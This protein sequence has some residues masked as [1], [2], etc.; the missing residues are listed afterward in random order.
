MAGQALGSACLCL[1]N[2]K[3]IEIKQATTHRFLCSFQGPN[4]DT[5]VCK[6]INNKD[7]VL[8]Q[9]F[10]HRKIYVSGTGGIEALYKSH[11]IWLGGRSLNSK[12]ETGFPY[13]LLKGNEK[14]LFCVLLVVKA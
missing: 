11:V 13:I 6:H 8:A 5:H 4:S 10:I 3:V 7:I 1:P 14:N 2:T 12:N 9:H